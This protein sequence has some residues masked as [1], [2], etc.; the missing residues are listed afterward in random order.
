M[1]AV[2]SNIIAANS[3]EDSARYY[4]AAGMSDMKKAFTPT[5]LG[6][7]LCDP[8]VGRVL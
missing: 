6:P 5:G 3:L 1:P 7:C 4:G 8:G 2:R